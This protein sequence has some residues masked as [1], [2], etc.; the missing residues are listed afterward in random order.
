MFYIYL[1]NHLLE[2]NT[3]SLNVLPWTLKAKS[4]LMVC[5]GMGLEEHGAG[6]DPGGAT[7]HRKI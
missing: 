3:L 2:T 1:F 4:S 5:V 7:V 6:T